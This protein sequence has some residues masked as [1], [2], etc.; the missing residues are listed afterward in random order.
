VRVLGC[1]GMQPPAP[2][3]PPVFVYRVVALGAIAVLVV[4]AAVLALDGYPFT[5]TTDSIWI[6]LPLILGLADVVL[7]PAVGSTVRPI[8]YGASPADARRISAGV[9]RVVMLLRFCLVAAPGLFGLVAS[10][11]SGSLLPF[12]IGLAF[13]VPLQVAF[14]YPHPRVVAAI[15]ARLESS[16]V[17]SHL[18]DVLASPRAQPDG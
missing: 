10:M 3:R 8:P 11:I 2:S 7:V 5:T 1:Q 6:A 18:A 9:W 4:V 14:V 12:A 17:S 16:G 13:A 15:Q